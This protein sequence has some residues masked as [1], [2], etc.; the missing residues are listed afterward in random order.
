MWHWLIEHHRWHKQR[1]AQLGTRGFLSDLRYM[2]AVFLPIAVPC[3]TASLVCSVVY[4]NW[5]FLTINVVLSLVFF[6]AILL[7]KAI[8]ISGRLRHGKEQ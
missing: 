8:Q 2:L 4:D 3:T 6:V 1:M 5:I 7:P